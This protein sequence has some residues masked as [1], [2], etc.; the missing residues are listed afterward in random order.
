MRVPIEWLKQYVT[1]R[2]SPKA[3]A[4]RLTM[5]GIAV[6]G[7]EEINGE[8]VFDL[9]VTPNRADCLSIIGVAREVAAV[10]GQR[11]RL[12]YSVQRV[13]D[14]KNLRRAASREPRVT[15]KIEDRTGCSRYIGRL[16]ERVTVKPS[17]EWMQRRLIACGARPINNIV[18]ITNYVLLEYGQPVHAFDFSRL[19][20]STL[21][22]R[23]A[24]PNEPITTLDGVARKLSPDTLVIA[25]AARPVAV[26]GIMGGVGSEVTD[27]TTTVLLESALFD[28]I[29]VRRTARKLGLASESSYRFERGVD[30]AGVETASARAANLICELAGGIQR[31]GLDVGS[32]KTARP[33]I[34]VELSRLNRWLGTRLS[35]P[36]LR[37]GLARLS[38]RVASSG[39]GETLRVNPPSFRRD[40]STEVDIYEEAARLIGYDRIPST[41]PA[42]PLL[43]GSSETTAQFWRTHSLKCLCASVG[44]T[45]T[46]NWSL[47]SEADLAR[48]GYSSA[49]AVRLANPLSQDHAWFRPGLLIGLLQTV[50]RN[51][52]RGVSDVAIFEVGAIM[53]LEEV[54]ERLQLGIALTGFWTQE[55]QTKI[56]CDFFR[57]KGLVEALLERLCQGSVEYVPASH[58]WS[59]PGQAATLRLGGRPLGSLGQVARSITHALDIEQGVWVAELSVEAMGTVRKSTATIHTP[60]TVPAVKRDLSLFVDARTPFQDLDRAIRETGAPMATRVMLIDRYTG[61]QVPSGQCSLTFSI[62]YRDPSRTLTA[63]EVDAVHERIRQTLATRFRA[64]LR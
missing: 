21:L 25:D 63:T 13:A 19:S 18:D 57:L 28:P 58:A 59:E 15:I 60:T 33:W 39:A 48:C 32:A 22:V 27:R 47:V 3:L 54:A 43:G 56:A 52:T 10:T 64:T 7:I 61:K 62:E 44:L 45:E 49:Q 6:T 38:C 34:S 35:A 14:S 4:E 50:R 31:Q 40:L 9:E 51:V 36:A 41:L 17:P 8:P 5:A 20:Q 1:I 24:Q 16:I 26:A 42:G 23:R 11:L 55:W 29:L 37:T 53:P 12:A 30:P 46:I 2:L